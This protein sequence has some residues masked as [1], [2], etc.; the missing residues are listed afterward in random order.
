LGR[1]CAAGGIADGR[2]V[3]A[4]LALGASGAQIGT[5]F[6]S[7][8]EAAT[9]APWRAAIAAA[10]DSDTMMSDAFSGRPA[11]VKRCRYAL[12]MA[13]H[14]HRLPDFPSMYALSEPLWEA[15]RAAGRGDFAFQLYGQA[16]A[17]SRAM[18]AAELVRRLVAET[19]EVIRSLA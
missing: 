18:P 13:G 10:T 16:A 5:G 12:E 17:L 1:S 11:R 7:C 9:D 2:G 14:S 19:R 8:P 4:A 15:D 6:L 3:A